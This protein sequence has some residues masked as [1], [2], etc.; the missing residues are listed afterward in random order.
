[1]WCIMVGA[2]PLLW[3]QLLKQYPGVFLIA[4]GQ[5]AIP[6]QGYPQ[7]CIAI[8]EIDYYTYVLKL[9]EREIYATD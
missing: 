4:P 2:L 5:Y 1:M 3:E 7:Q 8:R 9:R 6:S